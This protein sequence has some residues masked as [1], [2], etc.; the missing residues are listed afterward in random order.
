MLFL[1]CK[2]YDRY[3]FYFNDSCYEEKNYYKKFN[4]SCT[5]STN[6]NVIYPLEF[7]PV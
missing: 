1:H 6:E 5:V 3:F 7:D 2:C 4:E